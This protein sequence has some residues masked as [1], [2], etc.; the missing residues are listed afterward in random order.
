MSIQDQI[1]R[2]TAAKEDIASAITSKGV[3]VPTTASLSDMSSYIN[4]IS[5]RNLIYDMDFDDILQEDKTYVESN[6][7]ALIRDIN[8]DYIYVPVYG[9][10]TP[11][12]Y[13]NVAADEGII[14][15]VLFNW[16]NWEIQER[17][18]FS[19]DGQ[20]ALTELVNSK[21]ITYSMDCTDISEDDKTFLQKHPGTFIHNSLD[22]VVYHPVARDNS[23]YGCNE[24]T[25]INLD[26]K[27]ICRY[28]F[29]WET[30]TSQY[31]EH[32]ILEA[33]YGTIT[34]GVNSYVDF[35][36]GNSKFIK[37]ILPEAEFPTGDLV[38]YKGNRNNVFSS[39]VTIPYE[40][41]NNGLSI[42]VINY[43]LTIRNSEGKIISKGGYGALEVKL[44][45][46]L[47]GDDSSQYIDMVYR[48]E[49]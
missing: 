1:D 22:D 41:Y 14:R 34:V 5:T 19:I 35:D 31:S 26:D 45:F 21:S 20:A 6:E 28:V 16:E 25:A 24:Y 23:T 46:A 10:T 17:G 38:I 32:Q 44:R 18:E 11:Y 13:V 48:L 12:I 33:E 7:G 29:D 9:V 36:T 3:S 8:T 15:Y 2:L 43:T 47:A 40:T 30:M 49:V 42:E 39:F 4:Q 27:K 37:F